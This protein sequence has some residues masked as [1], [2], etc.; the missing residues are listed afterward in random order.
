MKFLKTLG[1]AVGATSIATASL[2][3]AFASVPSRTRVTDDTALYQNI[4][5]IHVKHEGKVDFDSDIERLSRIEPRYQER[6]GNPSK[7]IQ[8]QKYHFTG[9]KTAAK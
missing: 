2:S 8:A 1:W 6:L 9:S 5:E 3:I 4:S 7:R